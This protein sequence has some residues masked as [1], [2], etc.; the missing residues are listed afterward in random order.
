[1]TDLLVVGAHPDDLELHFGGIAAKA[2]ADGLRVV[3]LDLTRGECATRG[4]AEGRAREAGASARCLGLAERVQAGLPDTGVHHLDPVQVTRVVEIVRELRPRWVLAPHPEDA[5]PDHREGGRL[6]ERALYFA[7]VGGY[8]AQGERH[9]AHGLLFD[10]PEAGSRAGG[11]APQFASSGI[12][13]DVS[14]HFAAKRAALEC[15]ASQFAA[16]GSA[17]LAT[18]LNRPTFLASVEA[19][20]RRWGELIGVDFGEALVFAGAVAWREPL[21]GLFGP[22]GLAAGGTS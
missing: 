10:W 5:H 7:Q 22:R 9:R 20:A 4:T 19:R 13:I 8:P 6:L 15:Y 3:G 18:R 12:V 14:A 11:F 16:D 1:M 2:V 17:A 21:D